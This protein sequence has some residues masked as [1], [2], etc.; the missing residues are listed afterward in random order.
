ML[1]IAF[2]SGKDAPRKNT[3]LIFMGFAIICY[4]KL[5]LLISFCVSHKKY[6]FFGKNT[7]SLIGLWSEKCI[8][9]SK[10]KKKRKPKTFLSA[11]LNIVYVIRSAVEWIKVNFLS[12]V[13][14]L[15]KH[16]FHIG[17]DEICFVAVFMVFPNEFSISVI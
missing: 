16:L 7:L 3:N 14:A 5:K 11:I 10:V 4:I 12:F 2:C 13:F 8:L 6:F 9:K 15:T 1:Y 17:N